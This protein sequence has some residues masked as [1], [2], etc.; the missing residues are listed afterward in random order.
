MLVLM[1]HQFMMKNILEICIR[2]KQHNHA[3]HGGNNV[4]EIV[5]VKPDSKELNFC[6]IWILTDT[7]VSVANTSIFAVGEGISTSRGYALLK[8]KL[9]LIVQSLK[10]AGAG[11]LSIDGRALNGT[12]K[13]AHES[14]A[15][16]QPYEVN[17]VSLMRINTTILFLQHITTLKV[18][19]LTTTT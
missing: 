19:I 15:S 10:V 12:V 1:D 6:S 11:T 17:G 8:M 4:I 5:D 16:I 18:L 9:F 7:T 13:I 3:H 14:G 2:V